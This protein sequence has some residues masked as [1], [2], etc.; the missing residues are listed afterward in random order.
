[1]SIKI[2]W[3]VVF[4]TSLTILFLWLLAKAL[5]FIHT[6]LLIELIPYVTGFAVILAGAKKVG[7][8]AQQL[9]H[10][11]SDIG[12]IKTDLKE[13]R[14]D[15]HDLRNDI[16]KLDKRVSVLEIKFSA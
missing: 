9:T 8:Y 11:I 5:G 4:W 10:A 2:N 6:P 12:E 13:V 15:I 1:M 7:V 16:H 14:G 3:T